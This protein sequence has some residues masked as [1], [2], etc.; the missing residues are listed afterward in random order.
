MKHEATRSPSIPYGLAL[1]HFK[2]FPNY[3]AKVASA[4]ASSQYY[5]NS[6]E[7]RLLGLARDK[8]G[9]CFLIDDARTCLYQGPDSLVAAKLLS[10]D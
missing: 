10:E 9:D 4:I 5:Q 3:Q 6:L 1:M 8:L 2:F 7:Y